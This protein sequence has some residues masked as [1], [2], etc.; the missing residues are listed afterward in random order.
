MKGDG[1]IG[2]VRKKQYIRDRDGKEKDVQYLQTVKK[3][4]EMQTDKKGQAYRQIK[5]DR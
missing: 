1:S 5:K 3:K 4:E 2:T